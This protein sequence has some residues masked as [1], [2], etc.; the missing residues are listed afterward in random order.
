MKPQTRI[1]EHSAPNE[2]KDHSEKP[3]LHFLYW[4]LNLMISFQRLLCF[5]CIK[6]DFKKT[7]IWHWPFIL[8]C[9]FIWLACILLMP[10]VV[11]FPLYFSLFHD[12]MFGLMALFKVSHIVLDFLLLKFWKMYMVH[13][14]LFEIA[15]T[16][17]RK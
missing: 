15:V 13:Y 17:Q 14:L 6:Y 8:C 16:G 10:F 5:M 12:L 4:L 9:L 3:F 11:I 2:Q 1:I 7:V